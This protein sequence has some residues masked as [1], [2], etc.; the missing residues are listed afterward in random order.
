MRDISE[1]G[2]AAVNSDSS[3][4]PDD[5]GTDEGDRVGLSQATNP[6]RWGRT[7]E[8][9]PGG[10]AILEDGSI[11][12]ERF[13][14]GPDTELEV[15]WW[16]KRMLWQV[17]R[18]PTGHRVVVARVVENVWRVHIM[19]AAAI[20]A[21]AVLGM[22][23]L[24]GLPILYAVVL[25][26]V[27]ALVGYGA[28]A[29]EQRTGG[30]AVGI[31]E[32]MEMDSVMWLG[33][34]NEARTKYLACTKEGQKRQ[35]N[36]AVGIARQIYADKY[37]ADETGKVGK[38]YAA[39]GKVLPVPKFVV[40]QQITDEFL[41]EASRLWPDAVVEKIKRLLLP[42]QQ[43]GYRKKLVA[44][45]RSEPAL[46]E[47]KGRGVLRCECAACEVMNELGIKPRLSG[48]EATRKRAAAAAAR[49]A[50]TGPTD[51]A[52]RLDQLRQAAGRL[53]GTATSDSPDGIEESKEARKAREALAKSEESTRKRAQSQ[54]EQDRKDAERE[55]REAS[56]ARV[57]AD[58]SETVETAQS[59]GSDERASTV[60][61][62]KTSKKNKGQSTII[63]VAI[64]V[65][66][67]V[68]ALVVAIVV[69]TQPK[70]TDVPTITLPESSAATTIP[71][72]SSQPT[73]TTPP[74]PPTNGEV[75]GVP[76][77]FGPD[78]PGSQKGGAAAIAAYDYAYYVKRSGAE[79]VA[80]YAPGA[81]PAVGPAQNAIDANPVGTRHALVITPVVV[82][83]EYDV[84][85]K[86]TWPGTPEQEFRQKFFTTYSD[87]KYFLLRQAA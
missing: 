35:Y 81:Q 76:I 4:L 72:T 2:F 62:G 41:D 31:E 9:T 27:L 47:A 13:S 46:A 49:Q 75:V 29:W 80:L 11:N 42:A 18:E 54:A 78:D 23:I 39:G 1:R 61:K 16:N 70:E 79:A 22:V 86:I 57:A 12:T 21:L 43:V 24:G 6:N 7:G 55:E 68:V 14:E 19:I 69:A 67:I 25:G 58:D 26:L 63:G 73:A 33:A 50:Q 8:E 5:I 82:G 34:R 40:P 10:V 28:L 65:G 84:L 36:E 53:R 3:G 37:G 66:L 17:R 74:A 85:L 48:A 44:R 38:T 52:T 20:I 51:P 83:E 56:R 30:E 87:G 32:I 64:V 15:A 77:P 59:G 45:Y 71:S 60:T